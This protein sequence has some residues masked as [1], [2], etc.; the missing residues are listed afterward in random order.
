MPY[1]LCQ[2]SGAMLVFFNLMVGEMMAYLRIGLVDLPGQC[3]Q[4]MMLCC[5]GLHYE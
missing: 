4:G 1:F 5:R 2:S 3:S